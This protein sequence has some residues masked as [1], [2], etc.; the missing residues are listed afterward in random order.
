VALAALGL[1]VGTK[2]TALPLAA[3]V[4]CAGAWLHRRRLRPLARPLALAAVAA[5]GAGGV[6][7][8]RNLVLHGSPLWPFVATPWGDDVPFL[9]ARANDSFLDA[10]R[11]TLDAVGDDYLRLFGGGFVLLAGALMAPLLARSRAVAAAA[12]VTAG[13][14]LIWLNAPFTGSATGTLA[15][16]TLSTLRYLLPALAAAVLTLGLAARTSREG[17][18]LGA[19]A[20]ALGTAVGAWQTFDL[21]YPSV[22]S[23]AVPLAGLAL[24]AA[25]AMPLGSAAVRERI[26]ARPALAATAAACATALAAAAA[27]G[28][29]VER[30]A[31]TGAF[32]SDVTGWLSAQPAFDDGDR[33]VGL[34]PVALGTLAG[35]RLQNRLH[36]IAPGEPCAGV[37]ALLADGWV[38]LP[39]LSLALFGLPGP[40]RCL[41]RVPARHEGPLFRV[42]GLPEA[43]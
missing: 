6:W 7:Y 8:I 9:V 1:A 28:G 26:R 19:G 25:L 36:L 13:S 18:L 33:T 38:V 12:A 20:L 4:V 15:E 27:A 3:V 11:A 30:Q 17:F 23:P 16:I 29:L 31:R 34:A 43:R 35:D 41:A 39:R 24:G 22:P 10:P 37:R 2:T 5:V 42:Y 14:V 40:R 32:A 21:G